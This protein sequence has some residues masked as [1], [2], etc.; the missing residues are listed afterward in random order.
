MILWNSKRVNTCSD[1]KSN[2]QMECFCLADG[3]LSYPLC[4]LLHWVPLP[5]PL[6]LYLCLC[7]YLFVRPVSHW[8]NRVAGATFTHISFSGA[9]TPVCIRPFVLFCRCAFFQP[10]LRLRLKSQSSVPQSHCLR[11]AF[12]IRP[13][14]CIRC[15]FILFLFIFAHSSTEHWAFFLRSI[16]VLVWVCQ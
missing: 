14:I 1:Y 12:A 5:L 3:I 9:C 15:P 16:S 4:V 11:F 13:Q 2:I 7:L 8:R 6:S 10:A